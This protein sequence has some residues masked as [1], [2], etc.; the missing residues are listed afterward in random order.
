MCIIYESN[1]MLLLFFSLV[2]I[3]MCVCF[4]VLYVCIL[5]PGQ[6][7]TGGVCT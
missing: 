5:V 6:N 1:L 4:D 2:V 3:R 7:C